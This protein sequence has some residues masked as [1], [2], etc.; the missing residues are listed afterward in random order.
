MLETI[1]F[2]AASGDVAAAPSFREDVV[3]VLGHRMV[4]IT[5]GA[6]EP[7]LF[8]HG[9]GHASGTWT[10]VLPQLARHFR[11]FAV[12]ML[13][14]G[15]SDKP[16]VEYN[17]W[18]LATYTR[19]FMDAVG[20]ERAHLVGHSLGGGIAMHLAWQYPERVN[21]LA[22]V[23][24]GGLGRDLRL[25]LRVA[26]L[27]GMSLALAGFTSPVWLWALERFSA[28]RAITP[29]WRENVQMWVRLGQVDSR[30]AFLCILRSVCTIRGQKVSALDRLA[31]LKHPVLLIW[32]ERDRTIPVAHARHA[33]SLMCHC[34]LEVL[35]GCKH[36]PPLEQPEMVAA[37][38]E[39][40]LLAP[41][42]ASDAALGEAGLRRANERHMLID[43]GGEMAAGI[44]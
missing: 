21:R 8:L 23:S 28:G 9:L 24:T 6:G 42:S 43:E 36:Y 30:R 39:R 29:T 32:G 2:D 41:E 22:L 11:V 35:P 38:L 13:G 20:I 17:L 34:Q 19:Y 27:P 4:Y 3:S 44:A 16:R 26:S 31:M 10:E 15:R 1:S 12:D 25:G 5:G 37:L 33:A 7:V 40:F 14:C 18:A